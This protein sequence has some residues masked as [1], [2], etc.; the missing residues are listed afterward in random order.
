MRF[1]IILALLLSFPLGQILPQLT[2]RLNTPQ[3]GVVQAGPQKAISTY[4][5]SFSFLQNGTISSI[6]PDFNINY[7]F[8]ASENVIYAGSTSMLYKST[9]GGKTW[10]SGKV[11]SCRGV[12]F[13]NELKGFTFAG[14][15]SGAMQRTTDGGSTFQAITLPSG[16]KA[17]NAIFFS[18]PL[19]GFAAGS[20]GAF[21]VTSD[22]GQTWTNGTT[23][24][25]LALNS[26]FFLDNQTGWVA[27]SSG[28]MGKTTDGGMSWTIDSTAG[29]GQNIKYIKFFDTQ[30][31]IACG[32]S[33][34]FMSTDGGASWNEIEHQSGKIYSGA[35]FFN[36]TNGWIAGSALWQYDSVNPGLFLLTPVPGQIWCIG[37]SVTVSWSASL[38]PSTMSLFISQDGGSTWTT[39]LSTIPPTQTSVVI[40]VPFI[41]STRCL[42]KIESN[43]DTSLRSISSGFFTI[44]EK[45]VI[46]ANEIKQCIQNN[47]ISSYS[48]TGSAGLYW[49][50]GINAVKTAVYADGIIWG[51]MN[52]GTLKVGGS[53]YR[54]GLQP[55]NILLS[56]AAADTLDPRFN[57]W[58]LKRNWES[59]P[60]GT[61]RD[62]YQYA[63]E[64]WPVDLGAPYQDVNGDGTYTP[65]ID[66][67]KHLGDETVWFV[68]N[69]LNPVLTTGLYGSQPI[70]VEM[71]V[72]EFAYSSYDL[73]DVLFKKVKLIN[74]ST[75]PVT[76]MYI[77]IWSDPDIG[78]GDDDYVGCDT[79]LGIGYMYNGKAVDGDG[80][81]ITY[82]GAN[83]PALG[84]VALQTPVNPGN[85][86][87]SAL[88]DGKYIKGYK[89]LPMSSFSFYVNSNSTYKDPELG[90]SAGTTQMYNY[91]TG[92]LWNGS[93]FMDPMSYPS[94]PV[95]FC[96]YGDPF[97]GTG[98][99][100]GSG[101]PGGLAPGDR[102]MLMSYGPFN[103]A[104]GQVQELVYAVCIARGTSNINS[105]AVMKQLC[106][107][108]KAQKQIVLTDLKP[109]AAKP[110]AFRLEQNY[111]NPF[112]PTTI[113]NYQVPSAGSVT[114]K[115]F[116]VLGKEVTTLVNE[117]KNAG[118]YSA[119]FNAANLPCGVYFYTLHTGA[120]TRTMKMMLVK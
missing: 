13:L 25:S 28:I 34:L 60:Q 77:S 49:P 87:D 117:V 3:T 61:E 84:Y 20:Y 67:P 15:L 105:V 53:T 21:L 100:E 73:K 43:A 112:N 40:T 89:N 5:S 8:A 74:K 93:P 1:K 26:M 62:Q 23:P 54:S 12:Y 111:P 68:A 14:T 16:T 64:N 113:I 18:D 108:V 95:N 65:G 119:Q 47:G 11:L 30:N 91:M 58:K 80:S 35:A 88:F 76:D 101:W 17:L 41:R 81:S 70:G 33:S 19:H 102:R 2:V 104:P 109:D 48:P 55:G 38:I 97:A 110:H 57:I 31:G 44:L 32:D 45:H 75:S 56:G 63:Y 27:S 59:L 83:P 107:L 85:S 71:Q 103:F 82:Y 22:G 120:S 36:R 79:I 39:L 4:Y 7:I 6:T 116:D 9:D 96:L 37:D 92:K 42:L 98:W 69:D 94:V 106:A 86:A 78:A 52:N 51:G 24:G 66:K 90:T 118:S 115:V 72:T 50:G 114:L 46:A 99:Y 29:K 10:N